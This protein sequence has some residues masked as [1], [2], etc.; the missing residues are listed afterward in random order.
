MEFVIPL[1]LHLLSIFALVWFLLLIMGVLIRRMESDE[2]QR[3]GV[4]IEELELEMGKAITP[5]LQKVADTM[6]DFLEQLR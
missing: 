6:A 5:S 3:L 4:A 2:F 1:I